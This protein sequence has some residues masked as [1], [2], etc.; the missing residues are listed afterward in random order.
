MPPIVSEIPPL[1]SIVCVK[2]LGYDVVSVIG[3]ELFYFRYTISLTDLIAGWLA[4]LSG[5]CS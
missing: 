3:F 4:L 5:S 2:H 1:T